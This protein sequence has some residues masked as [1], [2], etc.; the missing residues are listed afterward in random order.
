MR[1]THTLAATAAAVCFTATSAVAAPTGDVAAKDAVQT[2]TL[3]TYDPSKQT[4][5]S[6]EQ[7]DRLV[8]MLREARLEA[9][10]QTTGKAP[11]NG[12]RAVVTITYNDDRAP[13]FDRLIDRSAQIWNNATYNIQLTEVGYG[14]RSNIQ[15]HEGYDQRGSYAMTYSFGNGYVFL[16]YN[17][18]NQYDP[19]RIVTHETGHILG[20][21]DNYSGPC[22]ELMSGG[23]AGTSCT[24]T[25]PNAREAATVDR[26]ASY[27]GYASLGATLEN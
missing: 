14:Q 20:L 19:Q 24:N 3:S 26:L 1:L 10:T 22:S 17:Q 6:V 4:E 12:V 11:V 9:G 23:G 13:Q 8:S 2:G 25:Y 7:N 5:Q 21:P 27:Y 16:D 18:A 15:Y